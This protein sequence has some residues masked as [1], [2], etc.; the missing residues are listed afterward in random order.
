MNRGMDEIVVA[1]FL[2]WMGLMV[3]IAYAIYRV[4]ETRLTVIG[5]VRDAVEG[6]LEAESETFE[7]L[8]GFSKLM[9]EQNKWVLD[10][11]VKAVG[12]EQPGPLPQ[13]PDYGDTGVVVTPEELEGVFM[14]VNLD[15]TLIR[16][17]ET[18]PGEVEEAY[19]DVEGPNPQ[20][21]EDMLKREGWE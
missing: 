7:V 2:G 21:Y 4:N 18:D 6:Y 20:G 11:L 10:Q 15:H 13:A 12:L 5:S 1:A 3:V 19:L 14:E 17:D 16:T 8:A 9:V